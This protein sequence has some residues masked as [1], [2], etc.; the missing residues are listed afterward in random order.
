DMKQVEELIGQLHHE[1]YKVREAATRQL[2][3]I[4]EQI[5]PALDKALAGNPPL[6]ALRRLEE[7]R[8]RFTSQVLQGDRL[9]HYR[10]V[11][12][13]ERIGSPDARHLLQSLAAGAPGTLLTTSARMALER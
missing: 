6:E 7:M 11:E 2:G 3:K 8:G 4:G 13:L 1:Q 12:V 10:V 5:V 9:R